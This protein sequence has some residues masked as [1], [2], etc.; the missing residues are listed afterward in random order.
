M[1]LLPRPS[2]KQIR[3][4]LAAQAR[5][6]W[7]REATYALR[8]RVYLAAIVVVLGLIAPYFIAW[9][10][11]FGSRTSIEGREAGLRC[12]YDAEPAQPIDRLAPLPTPSPVVSGQQAHV[13]LALRNTGTCNWD[14]RAALFR[15]GGSLTD[16]LP[17]ISAT[18]TVSRGGV[19]TAQ[20][21]YRA[22]SAIGVFDSNWR[23]RAASGQSFGASMSF[24]IITYREG[25]LPRYPR[26]PLLT[27]LQ[28]VAMVAVLVPGLIGL[29]L[30]MQRAGR[31]IKEFYSLKSDHLGQDHLMRL[32]FNIG[33]GV[34]A[35][36]DSGQLDVSA[37]HEA[38]NQV[39]GPGSV[40]VNSGTLVVLERGG[41]FSRMAGP[42]MV[43]L[44]TFERVRAV[45]DVRQL[46][47]S[48]TETA[49]TK[50]GIEV[51][52]DTSVTIKLT[53]QMAN[54]PIPQ[55]EARQPVGRLIAAWLG[56]KA[57]ANKQPDKL[58]ASP[59]VAR[60]IVYESPAGMNWDT[61]V[62]TGIGEVIP[63]KML[64][65]LWAPEDPA[66]NPRREMVEELLA[67]GRA[68]LLKRGIELID[69]TIGPLNV[70]DEV[71]R[72]RREFWRA[73]WEKASKVVE[74]EG[75]ADALRQ[76]QIARAEAQAELIQT[77]AQSF[78]MIAMSGTP[79]PSRMVALK[80]LEVIGRTMKATLEDTKDEAALP[81]DR[82]LLLLERLQ[83]NANP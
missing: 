75:E 19:F 68:N 44:F 61:T 1:A 60:M 66:H 14:G 9:S 27:P 35:K 83:G 53:S 78:R 4:A 24:S 81:A 59:E 55:P 45:I 5:E 49:Q 31:F 47:R 7:K 40:A 26:P 73:S 57:K 79:Q 58:P 3:T 77:I 16:T 82:F 37:G 22:P 65:E 23:M 42:G 41:G 70:P 54:E 69:L 52:V 76:Q 39:G 25:E 64:D 67:K 13:E 36:A 6:W 18:L 63:Q 71:S 74:A 72:Q 62:S 80:M 21:P 46:S 2:I 48:K 30:A 32:L 8:R 33:K 56:F 15:E 12:T 17:L 50:D 11:F 10:I 34:S 28:L 43:T 29:I 51:K 38:I 20:V